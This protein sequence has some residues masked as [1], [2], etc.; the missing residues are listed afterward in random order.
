MLNAGARARQCL[1]GDTE[2]SRG[3]IIRMK[4][5][6]PTIELIGCGHNGWSDWDAVVLE[7]LAPVIDYHSI[8]LYTG[9]PDHYTTVFQ[10]HEAERAVRICEALIERVRHTQRLAHPIHIAFDEWNVWYRTR[11]H[12]DRVGGV[13]ERY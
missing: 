12:E 11:S 2:V 6:D 4:R 10:S 8:H 3:A 5:T 1:E 13:E 9:H 7:G